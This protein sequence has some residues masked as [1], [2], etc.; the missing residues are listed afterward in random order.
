MS[1]DPEM[2]EGLRPTRDELLAAA[3]QTAAAVLAAADQDAQARRTKAE[4]EAAH[5]LTAAREQGAHDAGTALERTR[6]Q[7]ERRARQVLLAAQRE[8]YEELRCRVLERAQELR[9]EP[10]YPGLIAALTSLAKARLGEQAIVVEHPTGGIIADGK[11]R[12]IDLSLNALAERA[13][14]AC[15]AQV[16]SLWQS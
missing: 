12:H 16:G 7:G 13:L 3:R 14:A 15:P 4:R 11:G 9:N 10:G 1:A 8:V 2:L 5:R 6:K